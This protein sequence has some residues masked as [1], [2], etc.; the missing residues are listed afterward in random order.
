MPPDPLQSLQG[1]QP[2][3]GIFAMAPDDRQLQKL[4]SERDHARKELERLKQENALLL[5]QNRQFNMVIE[6]TNVGYWDWNIQ[7]GELTI[8]E[9]WATITGHTIAN[10][11]P[12]NIDLW[13]RLCHPDDIVKS[14]ALLEK[15]FAGD[16]EYY[17]LEARMRHK[18]G[19]WVWVLDRGK[20]FEWDKDGKPLRMVGSHQDITDRKNTEADLEREK[21]LF[22]GGPVCVFR[23]TN[24][25]NR[26]MEYVSPNVEQILGYKSSD[27]KQK[28]IAYNDLI[29]DKDRRLV[30]D[31][32]TRYSRQGLYAFEQEYRLVKAD[33]KT[34]W[35]HDHTVVHRNEK[36]SIT[37]YE[38]Y[39]ID[40]SAKKESEKQFKKQLEFEHLITNISSKLIN[41]A[42]EQID[43]VIDDILMIIGKHMQADRSYIFQFYDNNKL[44]DNTHEWC[45]EGIRSEIKSLKG[46]STSVF[47]WWMEKVRKNES[48]HIPDVAKLPT[49]AAAEKQI[50]ERQNIKS[51]IA[52]PLI[53]DTR[54]FGYIGLDAVRQHRHWNPEIITVLQLAGGIIANTLMRKQAEQLLETELNLALK[55]SASQSLEETLELCLDTAISISDMDCGG[56]YLVEPS[57]KSLSLSVH[58]RLPAAFINHIRS[59]AAGDYCQQLVM[60]GAPLY[61]HSSNLGT[62]NIGHAKKEGLSLNAIAILP[63]HYK[64]D[65]IACLNVASY[66]LEHIPEF[67]KK[68][69]E[70][71][72]SHIGAAIMQARHEEEIAEA[73][74]NLETLFNNIDDYLFIIDTEGNVIHT[75]KTVR[76]NLNYSIEEISKKHVLDFHPTAKHETAARNFADLLAGI[77]DICL[78][79]LKTKEGK[80]IPVETKVSRGIW[81]NK[82]VLFGISRNITDRLKAEKALR[83]SETRF[84]E[85]TE[86]LPQPVFECDLEAKITYANNTALDLFG[87]TQEDL[88]KNV[89]IFDLSIPENHQLLRN[90]RK[91]LLVGNRLETQEFTALTRKGK[92]FPAILYLTTIAATEKITGFRSVV[93]DLTKHKEIEDALRES[94][95]KKRLLQKYQNLLCNIP[96]IIYT[97]DQKGQIDFLLSPKVE[98]ITGYSTKEIRTLPES[99]LSVIHPDDRKE[100]LNACKTA[101]NNLEPISLSYRIRTKSGCEK[102]IEDR[103]SPLVC[104]QGLFTGADGII[105]DV[106]KKIIAESEKREMELQLQ[107]AQRL[108]T[109]GTLA[110]GIAHDFNNILTPIMGYA[111]M[112]KK[113]IPPG[114]STED[115]I[116]EIWKAS[117]RAKKLVER[118]LAFSRMEKSHQSPLNLAT[119]IIEALKLVRPSIPSTIAISTDIDK[120]TGN[121]LA[122]ASQ[123]H[124]V[125]VN[126]CTNAY[127]AMEDTGGKMT[128][129]LRSLYPDSSLLKSFP[130]LQDKPYVLLTIND[131]GS[132]MD[133][134]TMERIFEPFFTTKLVNKGTGLG[135]SVVH[136]IITQ[137]KGVITVSSKPGKGSTF[138]I[139]L[140][141]IHKEVPPEHDNQSTAA[142][143]TKSNC[144]ILFVDDEPSTVKMMQTFLE[145]SGYTVTATS[146][147]LTALDRIRR[148]PDFFDLLITDL[149]MQEMTGITLA[150]KAHHIRPD[151][152]VVLIT[153]HGNDQKLLQTKKH[154]GVTTLLRK[155]VSFSTLHRA[156][157]QIIESLPIIRTVFSINYVCSGCL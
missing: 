8:N 91:K 94:E 53:S 153:G 13:I 90:S 85:L 78:V 133:S 69:L 148:Q 26:Q 84:R 110:G 71:V 7:T 146:S 9:R 111:E 120:N 117:E 12:I 4:Q 154:H 82:L 104:N 2:F 37:H 155:P 147:A 132:G 19:H 81:N 14:N 157:Q 137:H 140:P 74:R 39:I 99:W 107:H 50:L 116:N 6:G 128:I 56:I 114:E 109:I 150:N 75:N 35:V 98:S 3:N 46:L 24:S 36:G 63:V 64:D 136:G 22:I 135:L 31:N 42:I 127:H 108:E 32:I 62:P 124:Q 73:K 29:H 41:L 33:G 123:M 18:N 142:S 25:P 96:G 102:W 61:T 126:L 112:L 1:I 100:Y 95:L 59:Y 149:T 88:K 66:R 11:K 47:P 92:T 80:L 16:S 115:Y 38:G 134:K 145:Q 5:Q 10:L 121:I 130:V 156:I 20:V 93:L 106:T 70:T 49:E 118:I 34:V 67:A 17:E 139:Y 65:V 113:L 141:L 101:R 125:I 129:R 72:A 54:L 48:I 55:L 43:P 105:F 87:Y 27:F 45:T 151:L 119:I 97:T 60:K 131:T 28:N 68:A 83:E 58:K 103:K 152:P 143:E 122:D 44:M 23:W 51:L 30:V 57:D 79:P 21:K 40:C 76:Q 89:T 77:K 86:Q 138:Y 15:H 52:I 144:S